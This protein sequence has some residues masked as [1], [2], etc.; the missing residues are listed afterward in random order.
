MDT[1]ALR[2]EIADFKDADHWRWVLKDA[3][4]AFL[5]DHTVALDPRDPKYRA[6]LDLGGYLIVSRGSR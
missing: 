1:Q 2:L 3:N 5:A 4:G 6:L